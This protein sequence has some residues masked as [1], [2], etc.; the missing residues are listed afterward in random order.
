MHLFEAAL[1]IAKANGL[2]ELDVALCQVSERRELNKETVHMERVKTY[3]IC[4]E[5]ATVVANRFQDLFDL[6]DKA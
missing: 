5:L 3:L 6:G 2:R 1:R 4:F